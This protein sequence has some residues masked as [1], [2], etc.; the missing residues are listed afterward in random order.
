MTSHHYFCVTGVV[1]PVTGVVTKEVSVTDVVTPVTDVVTLEMK[2]E[3]HEC[4]DC[5]AVHRKREYSSN[6]ERQ[7]AY[8]R[9]SQGGD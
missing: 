5:G 4:V 3:F 1:T 8:R 7:S 9:R 6:A 2:P